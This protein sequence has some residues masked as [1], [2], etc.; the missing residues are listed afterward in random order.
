[1]DILPQSTGITGADMHRVI[2]T[3]KNHGWYLELL[4]REAQGAVKTQKSK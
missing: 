1:M 2:M 3:G 4:T